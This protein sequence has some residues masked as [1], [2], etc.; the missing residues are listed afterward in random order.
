MENS[1]LELAN[2]KEVVGAV[3]EPHPAR[4]AQSHSDRA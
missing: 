2:Q 4:L 3:G 1:S